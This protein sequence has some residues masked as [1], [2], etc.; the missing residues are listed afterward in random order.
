MSS[1]TLGQREARVLAR[2]REFVLRARELIDSITVRDLI[3]EGGLNPYMARALGM[4]T[5]EEVVEFFIYRRVE[6]SLGTSFGAVLEDMLRILL[7]G[8]RGKDLKHKYGDWVGWWDIVLEDRRVVASVKSGPADMDKDQVMYFAQRA[9]E[10][11]ERGW[12]PFLLFAYGKKVFPVVEQYLRRS[13][14]DPEKHLR[15]GKEIFREFLGNESYYERLLEILGE[16]GRGAGDIMDLIEEKAKRLANEIKK[17]YGEDLEKVLK[18][19]F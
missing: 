2:V 17:T 10:A 1:S 6:R 8:V 13:G 15:V 19:T 11:I 3:D 12:T 7:G 16:A 18:A 14:L 9:K 5:V 4:K